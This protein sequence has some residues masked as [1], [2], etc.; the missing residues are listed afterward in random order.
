[1]QYFFPF[2]RPL[3][4][5]IIDAWKPSSRLSGFPP[6]CENV[7]KVN[8]VTSQPEGF[9][10]EAWSFNRK[11]LFICQTTADLLID[12][13]KLTLPL[14]PWKI[15]SPAEQYI[16]MPVIPVITWRNYRE[17]TRHES[18]PHLAPPGVKTIQLPVTFS[19]SCQM[20]TS[21][22]F[23]SLKNIQD[24]NLPKSRLLEN[25]RPSP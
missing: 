22:L 12:H 19:M 24:R 14:R 15:V 1:M 20:F 9:R 17:E 8:K 23:P 6:D 18:N 2:L 11:S 16:K 5:F 10:Q 25:Y 7:T 21:I 13:Q 4:E 3:E